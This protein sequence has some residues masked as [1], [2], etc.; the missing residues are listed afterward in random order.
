M[1]AHAFDL[2]E[3]SI[4]GD[5]GGDGRKKAEQYVECR[6]RCDIHDVVVQE[7]VAGVQQH[8]GRD[9]KVACTPGMDRRPLR[10]FRIRAGQ[11]FMP[12]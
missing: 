11:I 5:E 7:L 6:S 9:R 12:R 1:G 8:M 10:G 3:Q 4:E 2:R